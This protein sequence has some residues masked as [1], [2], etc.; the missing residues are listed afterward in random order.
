M[1]KVVQLQTSLFA[2][3]APVTYLE[4]LLVICP[5][6]GVANDLS[7]IQKKAADAIGVPIKD[8][9]THI[10][11][12]SFLADVNEERRIADEIRKSIKGK[13]R[14]SFVW[15]DNYGCH[16]SSGT[17]YIKSKPTQ[18]FKSIQQAIYPGLILCSAV[19]KSSKIDFYNEPHI[20]VITSSG[21]KKFAEY[22]PVF[23]DKKYENK[24]IVDRLVL[25]K[26]DSREDIYNLVAEIKL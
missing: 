26:K 4:Y 9:N 16:S 10:V 6:A 5:D 12:A 25:L 24:F 20:P 1:N 18:Y 7:Y 13:I 23:K 11:L 3:Y 19:Q 14:V 8:N 15:L 17:I 2:T 22:W 21:K